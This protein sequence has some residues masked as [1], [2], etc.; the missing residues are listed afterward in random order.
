MASMSEFH[1]PWTLILLGFLLGQSSGGAT[2][3]ALL[4]TWK[5]W[6]NT[7]IVPFY[8]V[9]ILLYISVRLSRQL[10]LSKKAAVRESDDSFLEA[11]PIDESEEG[12]INMTGAFKLIMNDNFERFLEVQGVPW[13][14]RRAAD[15]ARPT[16]RIL[17]R[18]K[19][20][21]I[22]I[23]GIIESE[24]TYQIDGPP[25]TINIRGRIFRDRV[26]Y[27]ETGDGIR[28]CKEAT[29]ENY[30]IEVTRRLSEDRKTITMTSRAIFKDGREPVQSVQI[31]ERVQ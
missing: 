26:T 30:N 14:L 25:V 10:D 3:D 31:F 12:P 11:G 13:A 4:A 7:L 22:Q 19:T 9:C 24:T 27:L 17:H 18:G 8:G 6:I 21:R 15:A 1:S 5:S 20:I 29:K 23:R 2:L 28:V 16:H